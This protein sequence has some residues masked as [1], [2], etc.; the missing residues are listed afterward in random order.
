MV[1]NEVLTP[2]LT[3]LN[4]PVKFLSIRS[5]F[6]ERRLIVVKSTTILCTI[7]D[8]QLSLKLDFELRRIS[9]HIEHL[10]FMLV[11]KGLVSEQF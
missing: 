1:L 8:K 3:I 2:F 10:L 4:P 9:K 7:N 6:C 5:V 11:E